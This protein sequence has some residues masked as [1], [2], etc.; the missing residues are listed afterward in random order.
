MKSFLTPL[1]KAPRRS[2]VGVYRLY[3]FAL[4]MMRPTEVARTDGAR[5]CGPAV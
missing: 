1:A 2:A 5:G 3:L 4:Y